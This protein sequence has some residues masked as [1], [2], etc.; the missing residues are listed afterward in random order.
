MM[1]WTRC[2][3]WVLQPEGC[4]DRSALPVARSP[5]LAT[6]YLAPLLALLAGVLVTHALSPGFDYLY[7][8]RLLPAAV[9]LWHNRKSY[10]L[11]GWTPS[12]WPVGIGAAAF[13]LWLLLGQAAATE[14]LGPWEVLP[15]AAA[16][17]WVIIRVIGATVIVPVA[18]ELAFRGFMMRRLIAAPF[19]RVPLGTFTWLSFL[20]SS[21]AFGLL[22]E[23]WLAGIVAG[24]LYALA[25]Y[26]RKQLA[27]AIVA[28]GVTNALLAVHVL[29]RAE[30][31]LWL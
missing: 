17:C 29:V 31:S 21:L 11:G 27:D 15:P 14:P 10:G 19:E 12:L 26:R 9:V 16:L 24:L 2:S 5:N 3:P 30:W 22:H 28:H 7:P 18:E 1:A 13:G 8:L 6:A 23:R 4:L 25:L 20:G